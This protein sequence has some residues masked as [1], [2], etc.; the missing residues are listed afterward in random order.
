MFNYKS[1]IYFNFK[2]RIFD[3]II[4]LISLSVF[5]VPI[6]FI[7][8]S[9]RVTSGK[10]VIYWSDR[11][12]KDNI[13]FK[14]PKFRTMKANTPSV[15][16]HLLKKPENWI[17]PIGK[18]LRKL[19]LDELPQLWS[20]LKGEMSFVGPR[21]AL[22]NQNDLIKL[23]TKN[24]VHQILPGITGLAQING[25]DELSISDK[26]SFDIEYLKKGSLVLDIK[27]ILITIRKIFSPSG[28]SH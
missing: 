19:S 27:I 25:R 17:T 23:R 8:I 16:T 21:P 2:K 12:G 20:I 22:F 14:M 9:I 18:I 10:N 5:I 11:I 24:S 4:L 13:I 15:A 3:L 26:V 28:I 6:I 1:N 7:Y